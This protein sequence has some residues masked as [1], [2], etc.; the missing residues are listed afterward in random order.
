[1]LGADARRARRRE[2]PGAD[3]AEHDRDHRDV[4]GAPGVL[5]EHP[6]REEHEHEQ[7][8]GERRLHDDQRSEQ[9]G[10]DLQRPAEDRQA[11]SEQPASA[12]QE[13]PGQRQSQ[14]LAVR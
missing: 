7:A 8:A 4:L 11:R 13:P 14:V 9:Q 2:Q 12:P 5:A 1:M 3:H 6:L 10:D